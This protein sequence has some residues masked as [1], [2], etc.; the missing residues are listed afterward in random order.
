[1]ITFD[2]FSERI[3][4]EFV[5]G[6]GIGVELF[7]ASVNLVRDIETG[8]GGD[9]SAPIHEALN[10]RYTRF[11]QQSRD[12]FYAALLL[13]EDGSTWQAKLSNP[14]TDAKGKSQKYETPVRVWQRF[15]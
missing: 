14:R 2:T 15:V 1:M 12:S 4:T 6:S 3:K 10:W 8:S 13:N 7:Q 5:T 11:S 9:V